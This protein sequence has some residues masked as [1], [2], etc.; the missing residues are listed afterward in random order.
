MKTTAL[1][2]MLA[3]TLTSS[4][5]NATASVSSGPRKGASIVNSADP[6]LPETEA[7]K[8]H[9]EEKA[10]KDCSRRDAGQANTQVISKNGTRV[11]NAR[12]TAGTAAL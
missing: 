10:L 7:G 4:F 11:R 5:A 1:I 8:A 3:L 6:N 9:A 2:A 12:V